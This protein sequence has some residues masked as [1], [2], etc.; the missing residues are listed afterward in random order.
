MIN[1]YTKKVKC[2]QI[3]FGNWIDLQ[4]QL[5]MQITG[6]SMGDCFFFFFLRIN[7][8]ISLRDVKT[9]DVTKQQKQTTMKTKLY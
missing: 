4:H 5:Q 7:H 6:I 8:D 3:T 2:Q 1:Q 9:N